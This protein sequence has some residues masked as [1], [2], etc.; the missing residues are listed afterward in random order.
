MGTR[1]T[2]EQWAALV[3]EF[4]R[5]KQ[6][7]RRFCAKRGIAPTTFSWWRW[8]LREVR[9]G[10]VLTLS[11]A[12]RRALDSVCPDIGLIFGPHNYRKALRE[13]A[14]RAGLPE[15]VWKTF[16]AYDL[17]HSRA[18]FWANK[19]TNLAGVA[20][21]LGHKQVTT[22]ARYIHGDKAAGDAVLEQ[23]GAIR[24]VPQEPLCRGAI[25][26]QRSF[27]AISPSNGKIT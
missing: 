1:R 5:T 26:G 11:N 15:H 2:R 14:K 10:R 23:I 9:F 24:P 20:Y 16:S 7:V 18:T 27:S 3:A 13:A 6:P 12:A 22:T 21:L 25:G 4:D 19:S 17:R 8:R